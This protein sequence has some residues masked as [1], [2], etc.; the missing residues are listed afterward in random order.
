MKNRFLRK[1]KCLKAKFSEINKGKQVLLRVFEHFFLLYKIRLTFYSKVNTKFQSLTF[2]FY[3][4]ILFQHLLQVFSLTFDT[5]AS[6]L[7]KPT[8]TF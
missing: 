3:C 4:K 7:F 5:L 1:I 2:Y 6:F 8:A